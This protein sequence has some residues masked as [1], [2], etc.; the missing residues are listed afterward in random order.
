M[1]DGSSQSFLGWLSD[2]STSLVALAG[3]LVGWGD[4]RRRVSNIEKDVERIDEDSR[5]RL[6][7]IENAGAAFRGEMRSEFSAVKDA[8]AKVNTNVQVLAVQKKDKE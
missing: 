2:S 6:L 1:A 8:I 3:A 5:E 7:R 4:M